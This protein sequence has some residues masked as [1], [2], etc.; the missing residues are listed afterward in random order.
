MRGHKGTR[1]G[2]TN[3]AALAHNPTE[4]TV[5]SL[6]SSPFL[7][8]LLQLCPLFFL[9]LLPGSFFSSSLSTSWHLPPRRLTLALALDPT[10]VTISSITLGSHGCWGMKAESMERGTERRP[11]TPIATASSYSLLSIILSPAFSH[12]FLIISLK[13]SQIGFN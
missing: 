4:T 2:E 6:S 13:C 1:D 3:L 7:L 12:S 8:L 9:L 11:Y 5:P 10:G